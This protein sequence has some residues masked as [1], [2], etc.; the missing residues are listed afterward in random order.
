MNPTSR[1]DSGNATIEFGGCKMRRF[2][3]PRFAPESL[4]RK[5]SPSG[6]VPLAIAAH[7]Y[8]PTHASH[9]ATTTTVVSSHHTHYLTPGDTGGGTDPEPPDGDGTVPT[10]PPIIPTGPPGPG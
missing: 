9:A 3:N 7:V 2:H 8:V 5:L 4:E 1:M 6:V 10:S